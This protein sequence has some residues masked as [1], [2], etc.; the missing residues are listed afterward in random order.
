MKCFECDKTVQVKKY[1][2]YMY[3]G[4]GLTNICLLNQRVEV[5]STCN[6]ETPILKNPGKLHRAI[7][8]AVALQPTVLTGSEL[9]FLRRGAGYKTSELANRLSVAEGTYSKWEN[10]KLP[11][12]GNADRL[13]RIA[14]LTALE[15][16]H[17]VEYSNHV[18]SVV[19]MEMSES[20]SFI[21]AI[22]VDD[23]SRPAKYLPETHEMFEERDATIVQGMFLPFE[24]S[25]LDTVTA[26]ASVRS[27]TALPNLGESVNVC[28]QFAPTA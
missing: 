2:S 28:N 7:G 22:N 12:G 8:V 1:R 17:P 26:V 3:G 23:L 4:V 10:D 14:Y 13:A 27:A 15:K 5:C 19:E 11:I 20:P 18:M 25:A 16:R 24:S 9:R 21:I 6:T